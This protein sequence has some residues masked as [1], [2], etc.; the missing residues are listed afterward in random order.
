VVGEVVLDATD[1]DQREARAVIVHL[2][3]LLQAEVEGEPGIWI[4]TGS[5]AP[6][7]SGRYHASKDWSRTTVALAARW[8]YATS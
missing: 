2:P 1:I 6:Y 8:K 3:G 7:R 4:A 5:N